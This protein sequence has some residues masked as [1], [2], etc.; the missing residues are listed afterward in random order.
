M[1]DAVPFGSQVG[2]LG[3]C[4]VLVDVV[5][6][7][8]DPCAN[9]STS[10]WSPDRRTAEHFDKR[11]ERKDVFGAVWIVQER[12]SDVCRNMVVTRLGCVAD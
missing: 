5:L 6:D 9:W 3:W 1:Y 10:A 8:R 7:A 4:V 11:E 12:S 2:G